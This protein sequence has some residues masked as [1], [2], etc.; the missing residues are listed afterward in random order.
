MAG[1]QTISDFEE[2]DA[3]GGALASPARA[4]L[5]KTGKNF[6]MS[7]HIALVEDGPGS[8]T[9]ASRRGELFLRLTAGTERPLDR[10][11]D[12]DRDPAARNQILAL[13][14]EFA[15]ACGE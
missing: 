2:T 11:S 14:R 3:G 13:S 8:C 7:T 10:R 6:G 12:F 5:S 9:F 15:E 1:T 4:Q